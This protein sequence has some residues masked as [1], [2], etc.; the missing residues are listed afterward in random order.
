[1]SLKGLDQSLGVYR[2]SGN[3]QDL[4]RQVEQG[5]VLTVYYRPDYSNEINIDLV[6][7]ERG[8][9]IVLDK[10]EFEEKESSL[11]FIGLIAGLAFVGLAIYNYKK[12]FS[13]GKKN[14]G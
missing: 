2:R 12:H 10:K 1:M 9:I 8:G 14:A 3:Y 6:Q 5:D 13:I 7:I 11:I 4:L